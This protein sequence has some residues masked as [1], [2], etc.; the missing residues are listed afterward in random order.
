MYVD[1]WINAILQPLANSFS[2]MDRPRATPKDFFLWAGAMVALYV[3][4]F[5]FIA[6]LFDYINYALPDTALQHYSFDPYQGSVSYEMASLIVLAPV[7]LVLMRIIRRSM[8][9]DPTRREIW[10][11]RWALFLTLFVAGATIVVDLIVLINTF[12]QGEE[13]SARFLLKVL[14]VL[15]VM[16]AGF[17]HFIS[18]LWGYWERKPHY[19]R[20]VSWAVGLLVVLTIAAGFVIIGSP[21]QARMARIDQQRINDLQSIQSQITYYYQQKQKLPATLDELNSPLQG[22][23]VPT[24]PETHA[25]YGYELYPGQAPAFGLCADFKTQNLSSQSL[26]GGPS[27]SQNDIWPHNATRTCFDR[28]IDPDFYPPTVAPKPVR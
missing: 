20:Y 11:R 21:Q 18:D 25:A 9:A 17:L 5:S 15:L 8:Q 26:Y 12:L 10:V 19:A 14:V 28:T 22:F 24:D 3:G 2:F 13:L 23:V 27:S 7:L 16:G 4:T 6:L 1:K